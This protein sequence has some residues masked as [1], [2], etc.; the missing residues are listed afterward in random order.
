M[1]SPSL[2]MSRLSRG[3]TN[4]MICIQ[5]ARRLS[6][7]YQPQRPC[8]T[9]SSRGRSRSA[10]AP[11][12]RQAGRRFVR[13]DRAPP[14]PRSTRDGSSKAARSYLGGGAGGRDQ[15]FGI[16]RCGICEARTS[17][18]RAWS[19][20]PRGNC[21]AYESFAPVTRRSGSSIR[22][23]GIDSFSARCSCG[24]RLLSFQTHC[25]EVLATSACT[26]G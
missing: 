24:P 2:V 14:A 21:N 9:W 1:A 16:L 19:S 25:G 20:V 5:W 13:C 11:V 10:S 18:L 26:A 15:E 23:E 6:S 4:Q 3:G 17:L 22:G 12:H 8:A 7:A